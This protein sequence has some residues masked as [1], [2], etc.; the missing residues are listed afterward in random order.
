MK[1]I[2]FGVLL[3]FLAFGFFKPA[4]AH[5]YQT[6]GTITVLLHTNP[7]DDPVVAEPA[8]LFFQVTDT[9]GRFD[10]A[11]CDCS[12]TISDQGKQLFSDSLLRIDGASIYGFT[13]PFTFPQKAVYG[14]VVT[15]KPK[16]LGAFQSFQVQFALR[17]DRTSGN[18]AA[19]NLPGHWLVYLFLIV[20]FVGFLILW[21]KNRKK[22]DRGKNLASIFLLAALIGLSAHHIA[23]AAAFC[24][25]HSA[26]G[27]IHQCCFPA[28]T[29]IAKA[30]F[31][32]SEKSFIWKP[33]KIIQAGYFFRPLINNKSPPIVA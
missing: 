29:D 1:K 5:E 30:S 31:E 9:A 23:L 24:P 28:Q 11:K 7:D 4:L 2:V 6:D 14:V 16:T 25:D 8:S 33:V 27:Q 12:V 20:L 22:R 18:T 3:I 19:A 15:G 26:D 21:L 32:S 17:V 10:A 13:I